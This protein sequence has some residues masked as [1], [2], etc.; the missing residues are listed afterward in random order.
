MNPRHAA[1]LALVGWYLM[2]PPVSTDGGKAFVDSQTPIQQ[3]QIRGSFGST[4]DCEKAR[5]KSQIKFR[6]SEEDSFETAARMDAN[7]NDQTVA[8][9]EASRQMKCVSPDDPRFNEE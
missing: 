1:A 2:M 5:Q 3:W 9:F 7:L 8:A 6:D 4:V